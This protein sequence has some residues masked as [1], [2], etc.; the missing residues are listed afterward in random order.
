MIPLI[1]SLALMAAAPGISRLGFYFPRWGTGLDAAIATGLMGLAVLHILPDAVAQAGPQ[2][3]VAALLGM[4]LPW[5]AHGRHTPHASQ[6]HTPKSR[7]LEMGMGVLALGIHALLDGMALAHPHH[8]EHEVGFAALT[9]GVLA[10]RLPASIA[11]WRWSM[12]SSRNPWLPWASLLG[13][14]AFTV[15]GF[16]LPWDLHHPN[17]FLPWLS[18]AVAGSLIHITVHETLHKNLKHAQQLRYAARIG[19][20]L[21]ILTAVSMAWSEYTQE[22]SHMGGLSDGAWL[23]GYGILVGWA[24]RNTRQRAPARCS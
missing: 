15:L 17:E 12:R 18:A 23:L 3:F 16:A 22:P 2:V 13:L 1:L 19:G 6:T 11:V 5:V 10:H 9:L 24:Y 7:R 14:G 8:P 21:G 20:L 4:A